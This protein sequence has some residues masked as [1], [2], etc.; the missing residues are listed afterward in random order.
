MVFEPM[1]SS[2]KLEFYYDEVCLC[3][4]EQHN[5]Y[6]FAVMGTRIRF[7]CISLIMDSFLNAHLLVMNLERLS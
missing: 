2:K 6:S 7:P 5:T 3:G 4:K 1:L